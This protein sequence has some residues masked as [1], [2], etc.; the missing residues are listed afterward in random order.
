M[1]NDKKTIK[2][3]IKETGH[4]TDLKKVGDN[5]YLDEESQELYNENDFEPVMMFESEKSP[6]EFFKALR[7]EMFDQDE[8]RRKAE[9]T[10]MVMN[11]EMQLTIEIIKKRPFM[12]PD[13]VH[14]RARKI[15]LNTLKKLEP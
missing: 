12:S 1:N 9:F 10:K 3:R 14:Q 15:V 6:E 13:K 5:I 2:A 8:Q 11:Y 7:A 4:I